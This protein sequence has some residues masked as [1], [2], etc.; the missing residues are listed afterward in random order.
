MLCRNPQIVVEGRLAE[1]L[2]FSLRD[3]VGAQK[4]V[5]VPVVAIK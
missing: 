4:I 1:T 5:V 2:G 3:I